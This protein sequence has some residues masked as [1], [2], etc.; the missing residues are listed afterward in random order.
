MNAPEG[1]ETIFAEA[2]RLPSE[3]RAAYLAQSTRGDA[4]LRRRVESLLG[5]YEVGDFLEQAVYYKLLNQIRSPHLA[6]VLR[7]QQKIP[8]ASSFAEEAV[9]LYQRQSAGVGS[10]PGDCTRS[11]NNPS[12]V[13]S[14]SKSAG[15]GKSHAL[16]G[17]IGAV[18]A[19]T[20]ICGQSAFASWGNRIAIHPRRHLLSP[21]GIRGDRTMLLRKIHVCVRSHFL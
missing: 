1:E 3:E 17:V 7:E 10:R 9:A 18:P 2:L 5:S 4:E 11:R 13:R 8:D 16:L 19:R 20:V 15:R 14:I 12:M 21:R 6:D